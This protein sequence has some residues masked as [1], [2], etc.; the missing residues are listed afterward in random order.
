M[1]LTS[2]FQAPGVEL[3]SDFD[4][5]AR[6]VPCLGHP[7]RRLDFCEADLHHNVPILPF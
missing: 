4:Q 1:P 3:I 2:Y 6:S 7:E 5:K